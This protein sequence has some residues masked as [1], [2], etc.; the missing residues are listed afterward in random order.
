MARYWFPL[1]DTCERCDTSPAVDRHH[2]D[3]DPLN[4][5]PSNI[6]SLCRRCHMEVDGRS[7]GALRKERCRNGHP[8]TA[9]NT[10]VSPKGQRY[11]R[12]CR[13]AAKR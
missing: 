8:Y 1:A 13:K 10:Y 7:N 11:C 4:N 9:D 6:Q 3:G 2:I 12:T 5:V